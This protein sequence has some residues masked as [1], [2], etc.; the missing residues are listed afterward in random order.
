MVSYC[1]FT[2]LKNK[3]RLS[4]NIRIELQSSSSLT[5]QA[6]LHDLDQ[7]VDL[8]VEGRKSGP[9]LLQLYLF[10]CLLGIIVSQRSVP[11][12]ST[13]QSFKVN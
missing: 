4:T 5:I 1:E 3:V 10:F 7:W 12:D 11:V 6:P 8:D 13:E 9:I 2:F